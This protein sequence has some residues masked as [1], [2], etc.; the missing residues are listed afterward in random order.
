MTILIGVEGGVRLLADS[1]WPLDRLL[2]ERGARTAYRVSER[3]GQVRLEGRTGSQA[4]RLQTETPQSI[5]R[6]LLNSIPA[7]HP[8]GT[9]RILP[10]ASD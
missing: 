9:W 3:A 1:D 4:C 2:A 8:A 7:P 5:A 10:A 6:R